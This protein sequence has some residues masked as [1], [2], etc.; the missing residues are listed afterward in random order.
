MNFQKNTNDVI[1]EDLIFD[2]KKRTF[3]RLSMVDRYG[4]I[5]AKYQRSTWPR[6]IETKYPWNKPDF[7]EVQKMNF[8]KN[9]HIMKV[10]SLR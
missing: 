10:L 8:R 5:D 4:R 1:Q 6:L 7:T 2:S 3:F 9:K